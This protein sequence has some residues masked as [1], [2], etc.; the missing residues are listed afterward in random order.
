M[1][2]FLHRLQGRSF[3]LWLDLALVALAIATQVDVWRLAE[4]ET[5]WL[6]APLALLATLGPLARRRAPFGA[7][8]VSLLAITAMA[9]TAEQFVPATATTLVVVMMVAWI[10]GAHNPLPAAVAGLGATV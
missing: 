6:L 10:V 3:E 1:R 5:K 4:A 8:L 9:F 7:P 2:A